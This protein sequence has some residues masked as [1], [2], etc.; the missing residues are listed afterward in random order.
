MDNI[1]LIYEMRSIGRFATSDGN[2]QTLNREY[3][4]NELAN[5]NHYCQARLSNYDDVKK[6]KRVSCS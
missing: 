5:G 4:S 3:E 6:V 2:K 1:Y